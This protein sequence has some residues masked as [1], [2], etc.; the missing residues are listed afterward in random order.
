MNSSL[1]R[2]IHPFGRISQ[3]LR[4][5][6]VTRFRRYYGLIRPCAT[7]WYCRPRG[8]A[9]CGFPLASWTPGSHVPHES[10]NRDHAAFMPVTTESVSRSR[11]G[12]VPG[13]RLKPGFGDI[14]T[15][16][17]PHRRFTCVRLLGPHLT[18]SWPA[19]SGTLTT[20]AFGPSSFRGFGIWS[21]NPTP[22][23]LPSSLTRHGVLDRALCPVHHAFVAH[24]RRRTSQTKFACPC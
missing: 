10:P 15:L 22:R 4:S 12:W 5:T 17:T 9:P 6:R 3:P 18:S 2:L 16:S 14:P 11:L 24:S 23:D 7:P 8:S 20:G 1:C 21:C 13:Q 19:F